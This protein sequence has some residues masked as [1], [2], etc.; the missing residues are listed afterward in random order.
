MRSLLVLEN[1][2]AGP[3]AKVLTMKDGSTRTIL[4][5]YAQRKDKDAPSHAFDI[6]FTQHPSV[7]FH[8]LKKNLLI[9]RLEATV[10]SRLVKSPYKKSD[11]SYAEKDMPE[12][13]ITVDKFTLAKQLPEMDDIKFYDTKKKSYVEYRSAAY[14]VQQLQEA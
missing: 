10:T 2:Y 6:G 7:L 12:L 13:F 3:L 14:K 9:E 4:R 5:V 1:V 11:G 8:E